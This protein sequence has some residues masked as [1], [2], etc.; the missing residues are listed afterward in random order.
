MSA[1]NWTVCPRCTAEAG[2]YAGN[3]TTF[4]EDYEF[5]GAAGGEVQWD[6]CGHCTVCKLDVHVKGA[7]RFWPEVAA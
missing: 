2:I 1:D 6:Y 5:W 3:E 4:R 7:N